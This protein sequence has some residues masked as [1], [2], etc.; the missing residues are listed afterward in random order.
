MGKN[1]QYRYRMESL[2]IS[3]VGAGPHHQPAPP[4]PHTICDQKIPNLE[5][6]NKIKEE[7][8]ILLY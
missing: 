5:F 2:G 8:R 1:T 7:E 6:F 3:C 4:S